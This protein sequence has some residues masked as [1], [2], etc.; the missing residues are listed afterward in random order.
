MLPPPPPTFPC[1]GPYLHLLTGLSLTSS[2][3][4]AA[5]VSALLENYTEIEV[6]AKNGKGITPLI[7][8]CVQGKSKCAKLLLSHGGEWG[9]IPC[10]EVEACKV[11]SKFVYVR[12]LVDVF[13][14]HVFTYSTGT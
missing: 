6:D 7:K 13:A 1:S 12:N 10:G 4:H 2:T 14:L 11:Q 8:A 9:R 5:V 3:G